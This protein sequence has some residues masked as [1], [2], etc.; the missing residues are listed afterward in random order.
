VSQAGILSTTNGPSPG[1][2][3]TSFT[4][5]NGTAVPASNTLDVRGVDV[6]DNNN[7]GIQIEGGLLETG[8]GNRFQV[9]LTNRLQ[10]TATSTNGASVDLITFS[11][12]ATSAVFR[13]QFETVGRSTAGVLVG[14]G[15]GY[16]VFGSARTDGVTASIIGTPFQDVD[17]DA[18]LI[19]AS[20]SLAV[21]GNN[22]ILRTTGIAGET[23]SYNAV[24]NYVVI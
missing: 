2:V 1:D 4:T 24:G 8:A 19:G 12:G 9:Q 20:I 17:E 5:D 3:A 11:L 21:S 7:N 22:V 6:T 16:T 15:V 10:G 14:N 13:F 23:I 18:G